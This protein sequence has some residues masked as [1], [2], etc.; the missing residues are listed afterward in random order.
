M[1]R[2]LVQKYG[3][4]SVADADRV[5]R[6]AQR[7]RRS[8]GPDRQVVVVVSALGDSTDALL[9]LAG[10]VAQNPSP[11]EMDML[12]ATGEQVSIALLAMALEDLGVPAISLTGAQAGI[13]TDGRHRRASILRVDT[14]RI[15]R[16]LARGRVVVVAGF[17]GRSRSE[18][19]TLGRGGSDLTAV[20]L[21]HALGA[22]RCEICSD[23]AGVYTADPRIVPEA[24]KLARIGYEE[25]LELAALGA[26]VLQRGSVA[27]AERAGVRIEARSTFVDEP[28]TIIEGS[29]AA[30][31]SRRSH[32]ITGLALSR[33]VARLAAVEIPDRP[34]VA[35]SLF[36]AVGDE[37]ID[38]D[39]I[40]QSV[41]QDGK[42]VIA[43]TV[44]LDRAEAAQR[45]VAAS[46]RALGG[47]MAGPPLP[48][49][50]VSAVG[51]GMRGA[52]ALAA[53]MFTALAGAGVNIEGITTSEIRI[54]VL[55]A[56]EAAD[57]AMRALHK[58]FRLEEPEPDA[59]ARMDGATAREPAR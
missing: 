55:V 45:V 38:V 34:G 31:A 1:A 20:A 36:R 32:P 41:G 42:N 48:M 22:E 57:T 11:R 52:P 24:R 5:R 46:A 33:H 12:L 21:A 35:A 16:E 4:S 51:M 3:G 13:H 44:D 30:M 18:T 47:R 19:T 17:Q 29:D 27:Y 14:R 2:I 28:G 53:D 54:S 50:L 58:A 15:L 6:V 9:T 49:A 40:V 23:V 39:M 8:L 26:Q 10:Q 56:P 7:V 43:F 37:G 59:A 25:M